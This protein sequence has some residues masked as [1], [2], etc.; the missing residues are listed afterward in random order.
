MRGVF[1]LGG[2]N[3]EVPNKLAQQLAGQDQRQRLRDNAENISYQHIFSPNTVAQ[4]SFFHRGS[5]AILDS[6]AS[7]TPVVAF[8]DRTL[9]NYGGLGS[10]SL[11]RGSHNIKFGGQI[12]VTPVNEQF[13]FYPTIHFDDLVDENGTVFPNPINDF[14]RV[15]PFIFDGARTGRSLSAY[16]QDRFTVFKNF[17]LDAGIRYDNY[18]LLISEQALSPRLAVAYHIPKTQTTLRA[19][20]NRFFQ[21]PPAEN[22]LLASSAGLRPFLRWLYSGA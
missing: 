15:N 19:S 6:N 18:K 4:L 10:L 16:V 11:T 1:T 7:S 9:N 21:P 22:L 17:T 13:S 8:Q 20:Y 5:H 12:T 14:N 3:F 2:S